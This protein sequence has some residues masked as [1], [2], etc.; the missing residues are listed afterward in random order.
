MFIQLVSA[1]VFLAKA[2]RQ[3]LSIE[4][5]R[6]GTAMPVKQKDG[7]VVMKPAVVYRYSIKF[8]QEKPTDEWTHEEILTTG[9]DDGHIDISGTLHVRLETMRANKDKGALDF[10]FTQRSGSF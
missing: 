10:Y 1:D 3:K 5:T 8:P 9:D 6:V 4:I 2:R 7:R